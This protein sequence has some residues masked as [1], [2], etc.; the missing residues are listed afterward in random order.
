MGEGIRS[1]RELKVWQRA[2]DLVEQSYCLAAL[3]PSH[4]LYGLASQ[5]RR[6]AV[7][8]PANIAE[9]NGREHRGDYL[10]HVSIAHG[11]LMELET[12]F[13]IALRLQYFQQ[14]Q[15]E[16][17]FEL[18]AETGR[19]LGGLRRGLKAKPDPTRR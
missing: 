2:M 7:S 8:I 1:Y 3:L 14:K 9:G 15:A 10:H 12:H 4:E 11:S 13:L 5:I 18:I 19:M 17:A 16:A 6:A